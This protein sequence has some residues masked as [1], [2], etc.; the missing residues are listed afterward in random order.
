MSDS[1]FELG[2]YRLYYDIPKAIFGSYNLF[3]KDDISCVI[4]EIMAISTAFV[5][6]MVT[7]CVSSHLYLK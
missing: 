1:N 6:F 2:A 5:I 4:K 7:N 3:S